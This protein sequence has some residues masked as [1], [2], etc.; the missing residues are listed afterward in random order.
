ML[1]WNLISVI[2]VIMTLLEA[3]KKGWRFPKVTSWA[4][5]SLLWFVGTLALFALNQGK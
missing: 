4:F 2:L 3:N 5:V 1:L